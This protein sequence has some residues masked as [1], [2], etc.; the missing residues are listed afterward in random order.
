MSDRADAIATPGRFDKVREFTKRTDNGDIVNQETLRMDG[1]WGEPTNLV[2]ATL[3]L[4][5]PPS[6][7][8][9]SF[10]FLS[11]MGVMLRVVRKRD[12]DGF[13]VVPYLAS[14][15]CCSMWVIYSMPSVTP[16]KSQI[17]ITNSLGCAIEIGYI[18]VFLWFARQR[19]QELM[20]ETVTTVVLFLVLVVVSMVIIPTFPFPSST[21]SDD[22]ARK[23]NA[24]LGVI[25]STLNIAMYASPLCVLGDVVRRKTT[26]FMPLSVT[27]AILNTAVVWFA[28]SCLTGDLFIMVPNLTGVALGTIQLLVYARYHGRRSSETFSVKA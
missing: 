14:F 27:L 15:L 23:G 8:F 9:A 11:P 13:S 22:P 17:L 10:F 2:P 20:I 21:G 16:C 1:D 26:E 6:H 19:R 7:G 24:A 25:C 5:L 28:W 18:F 3:S 4:S 12:V